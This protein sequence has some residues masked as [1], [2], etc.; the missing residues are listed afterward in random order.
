MEPID[1][2]DILDVNFPDPTEPDQGQSVQ[3]V[4]KDG[5]QRKFSGPDLPQI[6]SMLRN[7]TPPT[8]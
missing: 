2:D 6:L 3:V 5:S 8:A 1:V 7:W 4:F